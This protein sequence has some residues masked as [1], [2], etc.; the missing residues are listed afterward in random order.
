MQRKVRTTMRPDDVLTVE[1]G[2]FASLQGQGLILEVLNDTNDD[3]ESNSEVPPTPPVP[4]VEV[5]VEQVQQN[6]KQK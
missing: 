4:P 2:D 3:G 5:P 1:D 6:T